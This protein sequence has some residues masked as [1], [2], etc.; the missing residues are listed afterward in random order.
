MKCKVCGLDGEEKK[1]AHK[2]IK[3]FDPTWNEKI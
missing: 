1:K 3:D 2:M